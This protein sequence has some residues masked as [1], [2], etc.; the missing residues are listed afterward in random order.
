MERASTLSNKRPPIIQ[1]RP[2]SAYRLTTW[3]AGFLHLEPMH[4]RLAATAAVPPDSRTFKEFPPSFFAPFFA[5]NETC[6]DRA[7]VPAPFWG[8][9]E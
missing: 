7:R 3:D 9:S 5:E 6:A 2:Q 4:T 1:L 8:G